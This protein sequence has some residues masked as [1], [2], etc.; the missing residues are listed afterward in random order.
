MPI[1]VSSQTILGQKCLR[2]LNI[3][4]I[5]D[6]LDVISFLNDRI[7]Q[8]DLRIRK[9]AENGKY[10]KILIT[11]PGISYYSALSISAEIVDID[12][13][14]NHEHLCSYARLIPRVYQSGEKLEMRAVGKR[15]SQMLSWMTVQCMFVHRKNCPNSVITIHYN[16]IAERRN[17]SKA[18]IVAAR[19]MMKIIYVMLKE[20]TSFRH[21]G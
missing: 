12:R 16:K 3:W 17:K 14:E 11:M 5:N 18:K 7:Y 21:D 9:K 4:S 1:N 20:N 8:L 15:G 19:K 6:S 13:F 10:A 2:E